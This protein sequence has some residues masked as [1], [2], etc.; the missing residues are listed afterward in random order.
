M[1]GVQL[2]QVSFDLQRG[3]RRAVTVPY[4]VTF[5]THTK[6]VYYAPS[7]WFSVLSNIRRQVTYISVAEFVF[8]IST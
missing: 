1:T 5:L 3:P 2:K 6:Y 4:S 7:D 8:S